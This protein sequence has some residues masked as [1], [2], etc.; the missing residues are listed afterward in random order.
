MDIN[1]HNYE[2][3]LLDFIEGNLSEEGVRA[4]NSFFEKNPDL[5][6]EAE[7][8]L[9]CKLVTETYHLKNKEFLKKD[10]ATDI[11]GI[12]K[13]EQLSVAF[14]ENDISVDE[15]MQLDSLIKTSDSRLYEH[16][17]LQKTKLSINKDIKYPNKA[18]LKHFQLTANRKKIYFISSM[19]ASIAI[20][21]GLIFHSNPKNYSATALKGFHFEIVAS[22]IP[23]EIHHEYK[24]VQDFY[25]NP[26][27]ITENQTDSIKISRN[28]I[29]IAKISAKTISKFETYTEK[30]LNQD[31]ILAQIV[32]QK[33]TIKTSGKDIEVKEYIDKTLQD[34]GIENTPKEKNILASAGKSVYQFIKRKFRKNIQIEKKEI[35]DGRK[36]YAIRAGSLEF[37]TSI[38]GK[39]RDKLPEENAIR[40]GE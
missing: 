3:Y 10:L 27:H 15:E 35:E 37:Y 34:L 20:F 17:T 29:E 40:N 21:L 39:S 16:S 11:E 6:I 38:K 9:N 2:E 25:L 14:L 26:N 22:R 28:S 31:Q 19:A 1:R 36:L 8:L 18:Q 13:F 23:V 33:T 12:S 32:P 30:Q 24:S 5:K 4:V 7:D